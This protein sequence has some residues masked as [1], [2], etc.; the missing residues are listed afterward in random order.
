MIYSLTLLILW[1]SLI[2]DTTK[3][4]HHGI[5]TIYPNF[6]NPNRVIWGKITNGSKQE[7]STLKDRSRG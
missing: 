1:F 3:E 4:K 5:S 7:E 2:I 6:P